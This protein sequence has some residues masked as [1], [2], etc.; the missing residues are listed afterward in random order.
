MI[1]FEEGNVIY[2][3]CATE[4]MSHGGRQTPLAA[5]DAK[6]QREY[7]TAILSQGEACPSDTIRCASHFKCLSFAVKSFAI[8]SASIT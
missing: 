5:N 2:S 4:Y 3:Q 1:S 8:P 6:Q 7:R